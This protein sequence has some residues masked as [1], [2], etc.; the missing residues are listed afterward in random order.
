MDTLVAITSS[1]GVRMGRAVDNADI[2]KEAGFTIVDTLEGA[3]SDAQAASFCDGKEFKSGDFTGGPV[4][5]L[6]VQRAEGFA[7]WAKIAGEFE[8]VYATTDAVSSARVRRAVFP[9]EPS[10]ERVAIVV[11]PATASLPG[12]KSL[13][14]IINEN[15]FMVLE[16]AT[17]TL[18]EGQANNLVGDSKGAAS[19]TKE[20]SRVVAIERMAGVDV[21]TIAFG[22]SSGPL[23][24]SATAEKGVSDISGLFPVPF[25]RTQRTLAM[26]KPNCSGEALDIVPVIRSQGFA[27]VAQDTVTLSKARAGEFYAEHKGKAFFENLVNFMS[28]GPIVALVLQKPNAIASWRKV[29]G[30]TRDAK[31]LKPESLRARWG[32][33]TTRNGFHGSDSTASA[34]REINFFFPGL[35]AA[36]VPKAE[37]FVSQGLQ[38]SQGPTTLKQVLARGL[39][40]LC[41]AKPVGLDAAEWLGR[42]LIANNP[43]RPAIAEPDPAVIGAEDVD[44]APADD[45]PMDLPARVKKAGVRIVFAVGPEGTRT[46]QVCRAVAQKRDF[47]L[48]DVPTLLKATAA[49]GTLQ[50]A[51]PIKASVN[52]GRSAPTEVLQYLVE[53]ALVAYLG[54]SPQPQG[55][56]PVTV[57][58]SGFPQNLDQ[59]IAFAKRVGEPSLVASFEADSKA[60]SARVEQALKEQKEGSIGSGKTASDRRRMRFKDETLSAVQF[61]SK[62][63]KVKVVQDSGEVG[64]AADALNG[65]LP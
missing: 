41:R 46:T 21:A 12:G 19:F 60:L 40:A 54:Q 8:Y 26:I 7:A 31:T 25:A 13:D 49:G 20:P 29:I 16:D 51:G 3:L 34:D 24:V 15:D 61:Y 6:L 65:C 37:A 9:G 23:Y 58:L 45:G 42:W 50:Y 32:I 2:I 28:S 59:A 52:A 38:S 30:P 57:L 5:A 64:A 18:T 62:F 17:F 11:T 10:L 53:K 55:E 14:D 27:I 44:T 4:C 1:A 33:D 56:T 47:E 22:V 36:S 48:I 39:S 35:K 63:G 43:S